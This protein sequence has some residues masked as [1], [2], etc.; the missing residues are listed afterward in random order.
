MWFDLAASLGDTNA[1][2]VRGGLIQQLI[3]EEFA[4]AREY[5]S[6]FSSHLPVVP[7]V[8]NED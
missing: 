8:R 6:N 2:T 3:K 4:Q 5:L 1:I 7:V